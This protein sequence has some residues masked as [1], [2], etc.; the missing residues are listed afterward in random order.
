MNRIWGAEKCAGEAEDDA[1]F[2][3]DL[4][5]KIQKEQ[6]FS[7][8]KTIKSVISEDELKR[9]YS[10]CGTDDEVAARLGLS[11]SSC[12]RLRLAYR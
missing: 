5:W 11:R 6:P 1:V 3:A 10:I 12:V 4:A 9:A 2:M 7:R 8:K